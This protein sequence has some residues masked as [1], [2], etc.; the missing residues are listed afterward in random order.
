M[1]QQL[2]IR[3][4]AT[5]ERIDVEFEAGLIVLSGETGAGKSILIDA[6]GLVL[7]ARADSRL[8]RGGCDKAEVIAHFSLPDAS[9]VVT[10]LREQD[11]QDEDAPDLC[12]LRRVLTADGRARAYV[13]GHAV[14]AAVLRKLADGLVEIFGQNE[15]QTLRQRAVQRSLLDEFGVDAGMLEAV[16]VAAQQWLRLEQQVQ[17]ASQAGQITPERI[18]EV[19]QAVQELDSLALQADELETLSDEQT[20]LSHSAQLIHDGGRVLEQLYQ[21]ENSVHDALSQ[22]ASTLAELADILADFSEAQALTEQAAVQ[23]QEAG[24][25]LS[26]LI[27]GLETN[28]ERLS[29][30]EARLSAIH[31]LARKHRCQPPQLREHHQRITQQLAQ[32]ENADQH[33]AALRTKQSEAL[34]EY[35]ACASKLHDQRAA[36]GQRLGVEI[37]ERAK[38][39]GMPN[40]RFVVAVDAQTA[41]DPRVEGDDEVRFD[42]SAN[43]GQ[44]PKPLAQVASGGELSRISLALQVALRSQAAAPTMIF[45]EVDAGIGGSVAQTVGEALAGL[46]DQ[47]QVLCVTHLGQVAA[48]AHQH[49]QVSKTVRDQQTFTD[50]VNLDHAGR[51]DEISRMIGGQKITKATRTMALEM[52]RKKPA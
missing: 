23:V 12:S 3:N 46:G 20:A 51:I 24:Q 4:L 8:V 37:S 6:L 17:A 19:R 47:H 45:D 36:V 21:A 39:L 14:S 29:A 44:P 2:S 50:L 10:A 52:M 41:R 35:R 28:P 42:F 43:P 34:H 31:D 15:S 33:L 13:N 38:G 26:R 27:D 22:S 16:R 49:L 30:V 25:A 18:A 32:F 40:A 5:I 9:A 11:L 48:K 7:G 1:L